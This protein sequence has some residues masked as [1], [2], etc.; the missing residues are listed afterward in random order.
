MSLNTITSDNHSVIPSRFVSLVIGS[1]K[2]AKANLFF[3]KKSGKD[4]EIGV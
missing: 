3:K 1:P 4:V 2:V